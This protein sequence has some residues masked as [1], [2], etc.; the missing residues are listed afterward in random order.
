MPRA[1]SLELQQPVVRFV[2]AGHSRARRHRAFCDVSI[3]RGQAV[4]SLIIPPG[5]FRHVPTSCSDLSMH[6]YRVLH[7]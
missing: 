4:E 1:C 5:V 7:L 2:S 3:L 6:S